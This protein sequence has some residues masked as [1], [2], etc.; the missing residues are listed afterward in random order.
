MA[1]IL[2]YFLMAFVAF[3]FAKGAFEWFTGDK[4]PTP[5]PAPK[6][7]QPA[8]SPVAETSTAFA[9]APARISLSPSIGSTRSEFDGVYQ[10]TNKNG[11]GCIR[12][13]QDV[14]IAQFVDDA[15]EFSDDKHARADSVI[16]QVVT[17]VPFEMIQLD[18][19]VPSDATNVQIDEKGSDK[20]VSVKNVTGNSAQLAEIFPTSQGNFAGKFNWD[21][22][23]GNFIGGSISVT[24]P[25]PSQR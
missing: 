2:A 15:D 5:P 4:S 12:Y 21:A 6:V 14:W 7:E 3:G 25:P 17:G 24:Y 10:Q 18:Y 20:M 1:K 9:T 16:L 11:V 8:P 13:N 22:E 23:T 19:L